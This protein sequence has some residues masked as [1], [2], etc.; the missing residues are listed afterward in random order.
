MSKLQ[1]SWKRPCHSPTY[2]TW[3]N[4]KARCDNKKFKQYKDYGGR[5][6]T[7]HPSW[8]TYKNFLNDMGHRP[9]GTT[10]DRIDNTKGYFKENCRWATRIE[11]ALNKREYRRTKSSMSGVRKRSSGRWSSQITIEGKKIHLGT[12]DTEQE[13]HERFIQEREKRQSAKRVYLSAKTLKETTG[14]S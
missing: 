5:G 9:A 12:Y 3:H 13:A 7:Y 8:A 6:I 11:Q 1:R 2:F 4:M 10:L 14:N